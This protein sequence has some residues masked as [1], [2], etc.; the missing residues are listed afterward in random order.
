MLTE[1]VVCYLFLSA[2]VNATSCSPN[3]LGEFVR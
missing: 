2:G 3:G 1:K